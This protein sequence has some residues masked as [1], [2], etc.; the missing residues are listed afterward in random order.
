MAF[1]QEVRCLG[2]EEGSVSDLV[3]LNR[4]GIAGGLV[5]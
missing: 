5:S 2:A 4:P 3:A 1:Q